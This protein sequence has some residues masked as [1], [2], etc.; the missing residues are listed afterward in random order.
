MKYRLFILL[1][2][3]VIFIAGYRSVE[4]V[5]I[6]EEEPQEEEIVIDS[7]IPFAAFFMQYADS[8]GWEWEWL[9]ALCWCESH[10]NA[11]AQSASGAVGLMQ[12]MPRTAY[13]FGL[14]DSTILCPGDNIAAGTKYIRYLQRTF[15]FITN[16][17]ENRNFVI[18]AY[19][20][21]PAHIMDARRLAKRYGGNPFVWFGETEYWLKQLQYED[22]ASDSVVLY[23]QFNPYETISHVNK[24]HQTYR[25]FKQQ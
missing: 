17:A 5:V 15:S 25:R 6:V 18:A 1:L 19:N 14:N 9:A 20:A 24:V 23:G 10:F 11:E 8:I 12:L 2:L 3:T 21:G 7:D 16:P 22:Y 13:R 4:Q